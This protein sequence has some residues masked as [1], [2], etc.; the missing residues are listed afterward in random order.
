MAR[1]ASGLSTSVHSA[2]LGDETFRVFNDLNVPDADSLVASLEP[3]VRCGTYSGGMWKRSG[4]DQ[5]KYLEAERTLL[6]DSYQRAQ[7][8]A[9]E[10]RAREAAAEAE[11]IRVAMAEARELVD[12]LRIRGAADAESKKAAERKLWRLLWQRTARLAVEEAGG[13]NAALEV[14]EAEA[15]RAALAEDRRSGLPLHEWFAVRDQDL[16][17]PNSSGVETN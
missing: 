5:N 4:R 14:A 10:K 17:D 8:A 1:T 3:A 9:A 7:R 12:E 6:N 2:T 15:R 13:V 11:A 16:V